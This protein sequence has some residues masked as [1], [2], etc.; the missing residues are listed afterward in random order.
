VAEIVALK[1]L[2]FVAGDPSGLGASWPKGGSDRKPG[3]AAAIPDS[4]RVLDFVMRDDA[5]RE[6][7]C[8]SVTASPD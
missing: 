6:G 1:Q 5:N 4:G 2:S 8:R 3:G 7:L